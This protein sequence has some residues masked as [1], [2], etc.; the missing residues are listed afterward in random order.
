MNDYTVG[1]LG[2]EKETD[3]EKIK[4]QFETT[5]IDLFEKQNKIVFLVGCNNEFDI[6]AAKTINKLRK[7]CN[8]TNSILKLLVP[9]IG[10]NKDICI[11]KIYDE[12]EINEILSCQFYESALWLA[13]KRIINCSDFLIFY[14]SENTIL[15]YARAS[16]K[17]ILIL[18]S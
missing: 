16:G 17:N 14:K 11:K 8:Y 2:S 4:N 9:F 7:K 18:N 13:E 1:F 12:I 5:I 10:L 3:F 6:F 15:R